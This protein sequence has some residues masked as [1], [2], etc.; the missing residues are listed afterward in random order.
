MN[1]HLFRLGAA[2]ALC[3]A[4]QAQAATGG[5]SC[6]TPGEVRG[7]VGYAMPALL[8]KI[9]GSCAPHVSRGGYM[10]MRLPGLIGTLAAGRDAAWP[11]ARA[12]FMKFGAPKDTATLASL[13]DEAMRPIVDQVLA[14]K[15]ALK[16][17]ASACLDVEE[18]LE[19]LEPLPAENSV[20]L[21]SVILTLA[22]RG[23]RAIP[24]CPRAQ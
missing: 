24:A 13:P 12:A 16:V 4:A 8:E 10:A 17:P 19:T 14:E 1:T 6:I 11:Q 20:R 2:L 15:L 18:V 9:A 21:I 3:S 7:L 5:Q 22:G 23:D